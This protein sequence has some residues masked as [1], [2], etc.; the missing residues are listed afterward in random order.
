MTK[1]LGR[2][3][4]SADCMH[5]WNARIRFEDNTTVA[6]GSLS[7]PQNSLRPWPTNLKSF[8]EQKTI[9]P[10]TGSFKIDRRSSVLVL[11]CIRFKFELYTV[12]FVLNSSTIILVPF[13][14]NFRCFPIFLRNDGP[15]FSQ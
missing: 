8:P 13:C 15:Q 3:T 11:K 5:Q 9:P 10:G 1:D 7:S 2:W 6:L 14:Q 12:R 4:T